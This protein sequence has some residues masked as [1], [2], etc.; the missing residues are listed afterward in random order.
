MACSP[1]DWNVVVV[2]AWNLAILTPAGIAR[3]LLNLDENTPVEVQ[4][5]LDRRAPIRV[6]HN[7]LLVV[8]AGGRLTIA[9]VEPNPEGLR[10]ASLVAARAIDSLPET[11][12]SAAGLNIRYRFD[13]APDPLLSFLGSGVDDPLADADFR[14]LHR[15]LKRAVAWREGLLNIELESDQDGTG[16]VALNF[17]KDSMNGAELRRWLEQ[18]GEMIDLAGHLLRTTLS[19]DTMEGNRDGQD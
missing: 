11:P 14:V 13:T 16:A 19:L 10:E 17:H 15:A 12:F 7:Q 5:P 3:R 18:V 2:G 8:P 1:V 9:P 6:V 4:V